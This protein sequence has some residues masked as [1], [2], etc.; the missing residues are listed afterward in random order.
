MAVKF[1][2]K[3]QAIYFGLQTDSGTAN[4]VATGSL[5]STTAIAC[6]AIMGDPTRDTGSYQYL[7]DSLS[8][9]EYTYEKDKYIDLQIDTFQQV[10]SDMTTAINPNTASLWKL[11]QVC[12][13]NVI[14]DAT[15]KEVFVDNATD[16]PDYGT[17]DFRKSSPDDATNDKLYKFWDLRGTVDVT[18]TVGEVPSLKFSL[19]GNS[20]D[21][22]PVAKQVANFGSQTTR[23]ASS[24]LYSTIKTA[25]LV[26]ISPSDTFTATT[27]TVTSVAYV[28]AQAT[29]TFSAAHSIPLGEIRRIR[30]S[31]LTPAALNGDFTFYATT[32]T[33]GIYYAKG[34]NTSGTATGTAVVKTSDVTPSSFCFSTLNAANFFGYDFQRYMTGCDTGFAK[35]GTPTDVSVS[36]L[37]DQA[38][39]AGVFSPDTK[40]GSF[41]SAVLQFGKKDSNGAL[42]AGTGVTY[43][44]DKLQLANTKQGKIATYLGRDVTFRNTGS[45]F[46]FYQ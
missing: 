32:T 23:V 42:V 19:K 36:M 9:D 10:L 24:V 12:G 5:G 33:K 26:E 14:V 25:Q 1:H 31:G 4:K 17:A 21:P 40:A 7:G 28:N 13:G 18:A 34:N 3:N 41:F 46:I 27:G 43:M 35:G 30:V 16:S 45:S 6:T 29:I 2:E 15:T 8:R 39:A 20:D 22:V 44:W 38:N 11:Y 37:E